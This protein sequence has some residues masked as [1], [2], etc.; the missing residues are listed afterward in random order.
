MEVYN[1]YIYLSDT[2]S[3]DHTNR[4][5]MPILEAKVYEG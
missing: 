1:T 2:Y 5:I 4:I 3:R